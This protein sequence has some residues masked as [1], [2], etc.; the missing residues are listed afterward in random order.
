MEETESEPVCAE[1][2]PEAGVAHVLVDPVVSRV[3]NAV[4]GPVGIVIHEAGA[5]GLN[6]T[7]L[8]SVA[9]VSSSR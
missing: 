2:N 1:W 9:D 5:E 6:K 4:D 3:Q 7:G 8:S